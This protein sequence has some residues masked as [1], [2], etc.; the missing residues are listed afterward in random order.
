MTKAK[1]KSELKRREPFHSSHEIR[2]Q[3]KFQIPFALQQ[4]A[5]T[6]YQRPRNEMFQVGI[7]TFAVFQR[8]MG[9]NA[10]QPANDRQD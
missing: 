1:V 9:H 8:R 3:A 5:G 10:A 2:L 6:L 7:N 4:S